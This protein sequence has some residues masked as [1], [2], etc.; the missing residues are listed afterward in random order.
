MTILSSARIRLALAF[1]T[2]A[3]A[4]RWSPL[5]RRAT[6]TPFALV[7]EISCS[8]QFGHGQ[9]LGSGAG[10]EFEL[11]TKASIPGFVSYQGDSQDR[12]L[13][14]KIRKDDAFAIKMKTAVGGAGGDP[15]AVWRG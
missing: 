1:P 4:K 9:F 7:I 8:L 14:Q 2:A 5:T 12:R 13:S 6:V 11:R 15:A 10:P 3:T